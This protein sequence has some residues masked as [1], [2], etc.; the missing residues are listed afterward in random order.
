MQ[1]K[2]TKAMNFVGRPFPS[3]MLNEDKGF[4]NANQKVEQ[5]QEFRK[6]LEANQLNS[7]AS[8]VVF[9]PDSYM[10]WYGVLLD[11]DV[12]V[13]STLMKFTLPNAQIAQEEAS[14]NI[15]QLSLPLNF[16]VSKFFKKLA[17]AGQEVYENPGDSNTPYFVQNVDLDQHKA[18]QIWYLQAK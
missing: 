9:G 1:I 17:E 2:E 4:A 15:S 11:Q 16:L 12:K 5:D 3:A 8:M 7:R 14:G 18:E 10:Y 13:P 6:F